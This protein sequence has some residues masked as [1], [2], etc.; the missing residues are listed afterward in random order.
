MRVSVD[1]FCSFNYKS[2]KKGFFWL[3]WVYI[4]IG[5]FNVLVRELGDTG[6][7]NV[8]YFSDSFED[9]RVEKLERVCYKKSEKYWENNFI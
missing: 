9:I 1:D 2:F 8:C 7:W 3:S 6:L 4:I 5:G